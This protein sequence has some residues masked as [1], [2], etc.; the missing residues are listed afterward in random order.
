MNTARFYIKGSATGDGGSGSD[1]SKEGG[2]EVLTFRFA[3]SREVDDKGQP[4][5]LHRGLSIELEI[6]AYEGKSV[7]LGMYID[8]YQQVSGRI[9]FYRNDTTGGN[10]KF[11]TLQFEKAYVT[12]YHEFF[13]HESRGH[14][15]VKLVISAGKITEE[16]NAITHD[17]AK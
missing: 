4:A 7:L 14:M 11:R 5:S 13:D 2:Y 9:D 16:S 12:Y 17:W 8:M 1:I 3:T 15:T 6:Y 10:S